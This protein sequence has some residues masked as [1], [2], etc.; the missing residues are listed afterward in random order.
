MWALSLPIGNWF[1][2]MENIWLYAFIGHERD[3]TSEAETSTVRQIWPEVEAENFRK[4][5]KM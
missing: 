3:K 5:I 2:T 1:F 4:L